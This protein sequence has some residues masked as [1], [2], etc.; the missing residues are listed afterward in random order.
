MINFSEKKYLISPSILASDFSDLNQVFKKIEEAGVD[1]IHYDIMDNHFV[2]QLT[3]GYKFVSDFNK[4]TTLLADVHLMIDRPDISVDKYI[5]AG[6]DVITFH[7]ETL[8]KDDS[9]KLIEKIQK[10]G[11]NAGI[12]IKP[13]TPVKEAE[14]FL[15]Y[16]DM[17]LVM[18]VEPGFA[19]QSLIPECLDKINEISRIVKENSYKAVIQSDGGIYLEN[20]QEIYKRGCTFFV[21]GSAFFKNND[22]KE[23]VRKI[24]KKLNNPD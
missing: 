15:P 24:N 19:G 5:E 1:Y 18:T 7:I 6:S 23:F 20:I 14:P 11:I 22:Y 17:I 3:F 9:F 12:S 21:M 16:V 13:G 4:R 8:N 2:P 10:S